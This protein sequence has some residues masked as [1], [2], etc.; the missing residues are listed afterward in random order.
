M[1]LKKPVLW[2]GRWHGFLGR[3]MLGSVT[4]PGLQ[5]LDADTFEEALLVEKVRV[6]LFLFNPPAG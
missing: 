2:G 6:A 1:V 4:R 3:E 5:Y